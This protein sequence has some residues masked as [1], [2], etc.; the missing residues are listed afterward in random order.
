VRHRWYMLPLFYAALTAAVFTLS[1]DVGC[2]FVVGLGAYVLCQFGVSRTMLL[3]IACYLCLLV[4]IALWLPKEMFLGV[5]SFAS[6]GNLVPVL[7]SPHMLLYLACL[8]AV[9]PVHLAGALRS[10]RGEK[11]PA[12]PFEGAVTAGFAAQ[13]L[14]LAPGAFGRADT[15]H[16]FCYGS[17]VLMLAMLYGLPRKEWRWACY[18][19]MF[20]VFQ[21]LTLF[22]WIDYV[23]SDYRSLLRQ[24]GLQWITS[25]PQ[26]RAVGW[27]RRAAGERRWTDLQESLRGAHDADIESQMPKLRRYG[28]ICVP[29]GDPAAYPTL[30]RES[31]FQPEYYQG[32]AA[33]Y[34]AEQVQAKIAG[35]RNCEYLLLRVD[36]IGDITPAVHVDLRRSPQELR[37]LRLSWSFPC[38]PPVRNPRANL[39]APLVAAVRKEFAVAEQL[40]YGWVV[41]HRRDSR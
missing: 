14:A 1:P 22:S 17:G 41:Y 39:V 35:M 25:Y 18:A 6:G 2:A 11:L 40:N 32:F 38:I 21:V 33:V 12:G 28:R 5:V 29:M 27:A 26:S 8:F 10:L 37:E 4:L 23:R 19:T 13:A 34:T 36:D 15:A 30:A 16:I 20:L 9:V 24:K 3:T 7:P 31:A